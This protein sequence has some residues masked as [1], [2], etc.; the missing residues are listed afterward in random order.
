MGTTAGRLGRRVG[1]LLLAAVLLALVALGVLLS[2]ANHPWFATAVVAVT[3][4]LVA[5]SERRRRRERSARERARA[6]RR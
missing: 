1:T 3:L 4:L 6:R 5:E 2:F